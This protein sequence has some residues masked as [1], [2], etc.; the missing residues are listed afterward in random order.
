MAFE[1]SLLL[2]SFS[3]GEFIGFVGRTCVSGLPL[4]LQTILRASMR[5]NG[6]GSGDSAMDVEVEAVPTGLAHPSQ[7]VPASRTRMLEEPAPTQSAFT[8]TQSGLMEEPNP[9]SSKTSLVPAPLHCH[10]GHPNGHFLPAN[11]PK[12]YTLVL[13]L[14]ETLVHFKNETGKAKFL[15]RPHAYSFLRNMAGHF[16]IIIFTAAQK[17]Y[18]DWIL[19]KIDQ[20]GVIAHRLYREH[21][22][23]NQTSH[24]KVTSK[25]PGPTQSR[26]FPHSHSRQLR[27]EFR[28]AARQ[29]HLH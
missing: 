12:Q 14:D 21:C 6:V 8:R 28:L 20:H 2:E 26:P 13:D 25:G 11:A 9:L 7:P 23:M 29:R 19:D 22:Q 5:K 24:L 18:A 15:I 3:L 16:E 10:A 1:K 4:L 27:R 17:E